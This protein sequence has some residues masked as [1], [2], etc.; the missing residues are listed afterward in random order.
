LLDNIN[1]TGPNQNTL[2]NSTETSPKHIIQSP[3][4]PNPKDRSMPLRNQLSQEKTKAKMKPLM[5]KPISKFKQLT[6]AGATI[7][8]N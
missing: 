5:V 6:H 2:V 4:P 7:Q 3:L 8:S 1:L